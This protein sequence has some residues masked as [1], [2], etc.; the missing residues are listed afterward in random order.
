MPLET[1]DPRLYIGLTRSALRRTL[2]A[3]AESVDEV[4]GARVRL[5]ARDIEITVISG[6]ERTGPLLR[7]VGTVVGDR[8][9]GLGAISEGEIV[10]RLRRRRL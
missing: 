2:R 4:T 1:S 3:A 5:G 7:Q 8:L 6:A 10:V 9:A